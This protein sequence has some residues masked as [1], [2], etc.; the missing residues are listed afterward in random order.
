MLRS[1]TG[2]RGSRKH[3]RRRA[4]RGQAIIESI[5]SIILF[6][7]LLALVMTVT[8]YLY[9]QQALVT[10]AREGARMASLN[11]TMATDE[12]SAEDDIIA[13]VEDEVRALTG[14]TFDNGEGTI[15]VVGPSMSAN[16]TPGQRTVTVTITYNMQN[17]I[18]VAGFIN[19]LGGD[20][21]AFGT[22]PVTATATMRYE[23]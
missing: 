12:A 10:C 1:S 4:E 5:A 23:E 17:P 13:Y 15:E 7:M 3:F 19:A 2:K 22:I 16:Q 9:F 21:S 20:G 18:G 6:A 8:V 11:T 14:Q